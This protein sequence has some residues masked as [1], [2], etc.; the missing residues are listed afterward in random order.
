MFAWMLRRLLR[1]FGGPGGLPA[2]L[3]PTRRVAL[4]YDPGPTV[5]A[6]NYLPNAPTPLTWEP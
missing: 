4:D 5:A 2:P 3:A 1:P 6:L